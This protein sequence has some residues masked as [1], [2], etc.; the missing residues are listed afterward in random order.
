VN[1]TGTVLILF[2]DEQLISRAL[3]VLM[4]DGPLFNSKILPFP[5]LY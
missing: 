1:A 4:R 5:G 2:G 3:H